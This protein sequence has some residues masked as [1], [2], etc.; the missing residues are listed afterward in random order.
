MKTFFKT[1]YVLL[2]QVRAI[3]VSKRFL[4]KIGRLSEDN[5]NMV[6]NSLIS[7]ISK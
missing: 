5:L 2:D 1:T 6:I 4:K 7:L 3:D